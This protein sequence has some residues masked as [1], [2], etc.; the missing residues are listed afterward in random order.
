MHMKKLPYKQ[1]IAFLMGGLALIAYMAFSFYPKEQAQTATVMAN[2]EHN[3]VQVYLL[4]KDQTLVPITFQM[5]K[6]ATIEERLNMMLDYMDGTSHAEN[7][8][9]IFQGECNLTNIEISD[10][11]AT[12]QFDDGFM[13]YDEKQELKVLESIVWGATQFPEISSVNIKLN[14][15]QLTKMPLAGTPV[16]EHLT[17]EMGI[18]HFETATASLYDS[19]E[20]TVYYVKEI[21]GKDFYVPKSKR[22]AASDPTTEEIVKEMVSDISA[23]SGLGQ[24]LYNDNIDVFDLPLDKGVLTV[25]VNANI[26]GND[27]SVKPQAYD[28]LVLSLATI[29]GVNEMQVTVDDVVVSLHGSNEEIM[30]VSSLVYNEIE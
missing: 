6:D 27:Q 17:K 7:F 4:D 28:T 16:K 20:I 5:N 26:L 2:T 3:R 30:Q 13:Q 9:P 21:E 25:Q 23:S 1:Q 12:L 24:P 29:M 10:G 18:N 14:G 22:I 19:S 11:T 8:Y 15:E